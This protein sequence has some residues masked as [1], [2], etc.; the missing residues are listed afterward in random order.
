[1]SRW[2]RAYEGTVTDAK[3]AEAAMIAEVSRAVSIAAWH[4]LLESAACVNNCGSY[5]TSARRVS[6]ILVEPTA[7]I[8]ALFAAYAELGLIGDGAVLSWKKR[9]FHSDDSKE[10]VARHRA[11]KSQKNADV[12]PGNGDV[13]ECNAPY[14]E[15][16]TETDRGSNEPPSARELWASPPV[17]VSNQ[18]WTDF[19]ENRRRKKLGFTVSTYAHV[20]KELARVSKLSG[21]PPP[22]LLE[23]AAAEGWGGIYDPNERKQSHGQSASNVTSLRGARPD[24]ALDLLRAARAA[25]DREADRGIGPSLP[26]IGSG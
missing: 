3:L 16:E 14:T 18:I 13:T 24:P 20:N 21:I 7:A 17:P 1:M 26:A 25:E 10:R 23:H 19:K 6:I 5:E 11:K 12:T 22:A 8:E 15:T 2:Y 4:C 9:Q